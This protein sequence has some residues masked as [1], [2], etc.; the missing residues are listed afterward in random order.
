MTNVCS[1]PFNCTIFLRK[2]I[3][4]KL[5]DQGIRTIL[6]PLVHFD[7]LLSKMFFYTVDFHNSS[8]IFTL[9]LSHCR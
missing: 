5:M 1:F 8:H 4:I 7:G 3:E 9:A 2:I 6:K